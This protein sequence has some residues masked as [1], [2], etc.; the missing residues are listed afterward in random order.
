MY[1]RFFALMSYFPMN[2]IQNTTNKSQFVT[3][4]DMHTKNKQINKR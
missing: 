4:T 3:P 2:N 1:S